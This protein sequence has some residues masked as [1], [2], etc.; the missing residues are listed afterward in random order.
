MRS[1][2]GVNTI[3]LATDSTRAARLC[4]SGVLGFQ[5]RTMQMARDK[6]DSPTFIEQVR[7]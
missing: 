3:V 7:I 4:A 1:L 2:Y 5:C 6:F